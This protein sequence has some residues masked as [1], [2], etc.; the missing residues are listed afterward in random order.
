MRRL[1]ILISSITLLLGWSSCRKDF[2]YGTNPGN[3]EFSKDTVYLDTIFS[4]TASSTYTLKVYNP[5]R[6]GIEI[7]SIRLKQGTSSSYRLNVDGVAGKEFTNVPILAQDSLYIFIET[8]YDLDSS[9]QNEFLYTDAIVF[10]G[11]MA[12]QEVQLVTLIKDATFLYPRTLINGAKETFKLEMDHNDQPFNAEGYYL[13]QGELNFS[14][15]KPYIIYGYAVVPENQS[16]TIEAG[17][18]LH[19]HEN[20]GLYISEGASLIVNGKLSLDKEILENEVILEGDRLETQYE[21]VPGQWTGIWIAEGSNSNT[22]EHLTLKNASFGI[23][24]NGN[25]L[26]QSPTLTLKNT[27]IYNCTTTNLV[28]NSAY[29]VGENTILGNAGRNSL[30]CNLGG[31]YEFTHCTIANYWPYSSRTGTAIELNDH[32]GSDSGDLVSAQFNN[33]IID[34][35]AL[36]EISFIHDEKNEFSFTFNNSLIKFGAG[37]EQIMNNYLYDFSDNE[38]YNE[39]YVNQPTDFLNVTNNIYWISETSSARD[40]ANPDYSISLPY[41]ILGTDRRDKPDIGAHEYVANK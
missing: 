31:N 17:S 21:N 38:R 26:L 22:I 2:E 7:P 39:V 40:K 29:I 34:G 20:S 19:F 15:E 32:N 18:R 14:N 13:Q 24:A 23:V 25:G 9:E 30:L 41:D 8:T 36:S 33:C 28:G 11:T 4:N 12:T 35:N 27:Q 3:L 16:L 1:I 10:T 5:N 6:D 37:A